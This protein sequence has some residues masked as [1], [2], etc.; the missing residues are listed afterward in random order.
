[1]ACGITGLQSNYLCSHPAM[2]LQCVFFTKSSANNSKMNQKLQRNGWG[3]FLGTSAPGFSLQCDQCHPVPARQQGHPFLL[4]STSC[5]NTQNITM[6]DKNYQPVLT[7]SVVKSLCSTL[8]FP[9]LSVSWLILDD[10]QTLSQ[11]RLLF[12]I[13]S[14][15]LNTNH[16]INPWNIYWQN[17]P[18][19]NLFPH[20]C[21]NHFLA[22]GCISSQ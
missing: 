22:E 7:L 13:I 5:D 4:A 14:V 11:L 2:F 19:G 18:Y 10:L 15:V 12:Q 6:L 17:L 1:M 21:F 9:S 3:S 20:W 16:C 8:I